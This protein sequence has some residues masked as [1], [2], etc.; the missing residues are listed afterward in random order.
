M[1]VLCFVLVIVLLNN[2]CTIS[3][4]YFKYILSIYTIKIIHIS[5][6]HQKFPAP[7]IPRPRNH[8]KCNYFWPSFFL[9]FL[10]IVG[11]LSMLLHVFIAHSFSLLYSITLHYHIATIQKCFELTSSNI[12]KVLRM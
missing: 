8:T 2:R 6:S 10:V 7:Q 9:P 11:D 4:I 1:E 3:Y 5:I 12:R